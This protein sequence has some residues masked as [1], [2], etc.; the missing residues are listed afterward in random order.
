VPITIRFPEPVI[1]WHIGMQR[2]VAAKAG[3]NV[4]GSQAR[5]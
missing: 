3:K 1:M 2:T 5:C 4:D